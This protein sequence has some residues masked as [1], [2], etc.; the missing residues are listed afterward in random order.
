[1]SLMVQHRSD[2]IGQEFSVYPQVVSNNILYETHVPASAPQGAEKLLN[3]RLATSDIERNLAQMLIN[4][5]YDWR[6][7]GNSHNIPSTDIHSTFF[8]TL[9]EDVVGTITLAVDTDGGLAADGIFRDEINTFRRVPGA[10][11]CELTKFAFD[12]EIPSRKLLASLFHIVFLYGKRRYRCT[13]LFIE[14]NPR[15]RRFYEA[16]LGFKPIGGV[17][18][19][20]S[21]DAPA[22]LMWLKVSDIAARISEHAGC[23]HVESARSLYPLFLSRVDQ[24]KVRAQLSRSLIARRASDNMS[25][26]SPC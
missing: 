9:D 3:V 8:A 26:M 23:R 25:L 14:V 6:G 16:M 4:R 2:F 11:V 13:D 12:T 22:Q 20:T 19:N 5:M 18:T 21:V 7:Y 17:K 10:R 15:H 1:M 24:R